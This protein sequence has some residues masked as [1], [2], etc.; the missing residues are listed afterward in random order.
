MRILITNIQLNHRTGTEIFVR[1]L[2]A[3]LKS[4]GHE[5]LIYTP[6]PGVI[7]D[8]V[9]ALGI[10]VFTRLADVDAAPDVIHGHHCVQTLAAVRR[11]PRTPAIFVSHSHDADQDKAPRHPAI[12]RYFGVSQVCIDRLVRDGLPEG[13]VEFLANFVDT[14]RFLPR[15]PLPPRPRRAL[16]FSNYARS[17]THLPAVV[18]ACRRAR[19]ELDV[20]G[21]WNGNPVDAPERLLGQYDL[22]FA[23]AKSAIEAMAVGT[24][25]VLCDYAGVGPAV[26]TSNF[27]ALRRMNFGFQ[28]LS[29]PLTPEAVLASMDAHDPEE[30]AQV[31]DII[32]SVATVEAAVDFLLGVYEEV[33]HQGP[34]GQKM[35]LGETVSLYLWEIRQRLGLNSQRLRSSLRQRVEPER[36]L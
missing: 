33:L 2:A 12:R 25:V 18:E 24:A 20:V 21:L 6:A 7:S 11:F 34:P 26:N 29:G 13:R 28:A 27:W 22:V 8:E 10:P 16:V 23:K 15:P 1:D 5:P 31:R 3:E 14:R 9:Q 36:R 4:R 35:R 32:R 30:A 17:D 19:V